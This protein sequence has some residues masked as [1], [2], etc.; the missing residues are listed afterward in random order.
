M[1]QLQS[2]I[3]RLERQ[4]NGGSLSA[5]AVKKEEEE[6]M[7]DSVLREKCCQLE[8]QIKKLKL[9]IT[10]IERQSELSSAEGEE[11][12]QKLSSENM[13]LVQVNSQLEQKL[14]AEQVN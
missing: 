8:D 11:K 9:K 12:C 2:T 5:T 14:K 7:K 3:N 1:D 13:R 4:I 6:R 10:D